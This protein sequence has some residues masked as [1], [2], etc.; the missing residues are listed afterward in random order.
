MDILGLTGAGWRVMVVSN[1]FVRSLVHQNEPHAH[2]Y[3]DGRDVEV[4]QDN[5]KV[6]LLKHTDDAA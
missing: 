3:V 1:H 6:G 5:R 2:Q 4:W